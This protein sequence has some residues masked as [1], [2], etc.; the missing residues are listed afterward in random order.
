MASIVKKT[1]DGRIKRQERCHLRK[2]ELY[3]RPEW[4]NIVGNALYDGLE[5][6]T[7]VLEGR[8]ITTLKA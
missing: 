4:I 6:E 1:L 3:Q 8:P 5:G 7:V 2:L